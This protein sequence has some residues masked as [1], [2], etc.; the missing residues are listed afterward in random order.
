MLGPQERI[1]SVFCTDGACF[2]DK[3]A[4][5]REK[6]SVAVLRYIIYKCIYSNVYVLEELV[7][8]HLKRFRKTQE[9]LQNTLLC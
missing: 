8:P 2:M 4:A 6:G 9:H 1:N 3:P 5:T 7:S